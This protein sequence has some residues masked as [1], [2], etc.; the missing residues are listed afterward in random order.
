MRGEPIADVL[1][2]T[3][4][5]GWPQFLRRMES[6]GGPKEAR[7]GADGTFAVRAPR[8]GGTTFEVVASRPGLATSRAGPFPQDGG[9]AGWPFVEIQLGEGASVEGRVTSLDG[10]PVS[11]ARVR[12]WRDAQVP[13]EATLFT[14]LLPQSVGE[15]AYSAKDGTYRLRRIEPGSY[16]VEGRA[17][18]YARKTLGPVEVRAESSPAR[19]DFALEPGG[20]LAG[21]VVDHE[22]KP[23]R[24]I[25]VVAFPLGETSSPPPDEEDELVQSGALGAAA[26]V[27][28]ADGAYAVDHLAGGE[29]RV[30]ARARGFEPAS[31][32]PVV[33]GEPLAD[34]V[35][36]PH[37]RIA[38][39]VR[40]TATGALLQSFEVRLDRKDA[41]GAFR[42]DHRMARD[43]DDAS[44]RF[45]CEGLR[46]GE[47]RVRV[48]S[49][50][51][52]AWQ[53]AVSVPPG[54][55]VELDVVLAPGGRIQ[56]AVRRPD[57][58]PIAGASVNARIEGERREGARRD[59]EPV[60]S[61]EDGAFVFAGLEGGS[62]RVEAVHPDHYAEPA[63]GA[64]KVELS[65]AE[66]A[67]VEFVLRPAG[68]V[69][70]R[71]RGLVFKQPGTDIYVVV[72]SPIA[73]APTAAPSAPSFQVWADENGTVERHSVRPGRY[74]LE[75]TH[76]RRGP[77]TGDEWVVVPPEN[78]PLGEIE[79]RA[80]EMAT[81][82]GVP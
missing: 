3:E 20:S 45:A 5:P 6:G 59:L 58:T 49:R 76:R 60:R 54:E 42:E 24:G 75:L 31:I 33:P 7:T 62:Y 46:A 28:D 38:G 69:L 9:E 64:A 25:E 13:E 44:G 47:W 81:F 48:L 68:K 27:T 53:G 12:I 22:G 39:R 2:G 61:G 1:V 21:R 50:E 14:Q 18:G 34:L 4:V 37:A 66:A 79:V 55:E 51:H 63:E 30:L 17:Q 32:A 40:D 65:A 57:G 11:G 71:I 56:G 41:E 26:A 23:L 72:F 67:A 29:H 8:I 43:V 19:I 36:V 73:A 10:A 15:A 16:R 35:L 78:R 70:G 80:G 52:A 74:R 77:D 82:E